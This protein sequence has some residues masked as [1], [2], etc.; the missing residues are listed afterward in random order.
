MNSSD[1][2]SPF[3]SPMS[4][5][6]GDVPPEV[7]AGPAPGSDRSPDG[8]SGEERVLL[9]DDDEPVRETVAEMLRI[10]GYRCDCASGVTEAFDLLSREAFDLVITDMH[11]PG[12]SG[13]DLVEGLRERDDSIP[14]ILITGFP[15][16]NAAISAMKLGAIDFITKPFDI[17]VIAQI[18]GKALRERR[19][20]Q[21][22]KRLQEES[23]K[24]AVIERLNRRLAARVEELERLY[25][26]S[27]AFTQFMNVEAIFGHVVELAAKVTGAQRVSLMMLDRGRRALRIRASIGVPDEVVRSTRVPLGEGISGRIAR[28]GGVVRATRHVHATFES[29]RDSLGLGKYV[30]Q[31]WLALPLVVGGRV[32]GVLNLTDKPDRSDFTAAEEQIARILLEKAGAKL[33]NQALYE[34][35]YSN[36]VDTLT[37]LVNSLEAKDPYTRRHSHRVTDYSVRIGRV[38]GLGAAELEML[39][40]SGLLHD[41][42]KIGVR[43]EIL[44]K[45]G[46]LDPDEY[47]A[48]K[49]HVILGDRIAEPLGLSPQERSVIRN[50]H[51]RFD[52]RGYP[53]R[54]A[55]E[56]IPLL[57]RIV[58]VADAFDAMTSTRP[59]RLALSSERALA[60]L[61]RNAGIQFD[62][63]IVEMA[64]TGLAGLPAE[65]SGA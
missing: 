17:R 57:A 5:G 50:H 20:R 45:P 9:V 28:E 58:A 18:V 54:L 44:T 42:G 4:L 23:H 34:G 14:V 10:A 24:A 13:L 46:A 53:D 26:I 62:P 27:E 59:Y 33:E 12:R 7:L 11:M 16:V 51:E 38:A 63:A 41:I 36:L 35:I 8:V 29:R 6:I 22:V 56:E 15:S 55:G 19:L 2:A 21:E 61:R 32:F 60:E 49:Q 43:D 52:G 64:A 65:E 40:F 3:A 30:S 39:E 31:S 48:I 25:T 37:A 1:L 47:E